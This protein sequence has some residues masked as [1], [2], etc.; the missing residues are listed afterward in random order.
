MTNVAHHSVV[1]HC[2]HVFSR[3]D[4]AVAGGCYKYV[5]V[6]DHIVQP[7]NFE[8]FHRSL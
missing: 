4:V 7:V 2:T 1:F 5:D 3:N 6:T 8:S